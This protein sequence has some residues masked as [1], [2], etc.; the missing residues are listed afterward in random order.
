MLYTCTY[1]Y[2]YIYI[3]TYIHTYQGQKQLVAW[4]SISTSPP[5]RA[6]LQG[7]ASLRRHGPAPQRRPQARLEAVEEPLLA[8]SRHVRLG[9][10]AARCAARAS[11]SQNGCGR[12]RTA[13]AS[14]HAVWQRTASRHPDATQMPPMCHRATS[15][16]RASHRV[17]S[18]PRAAPIP[19][20]LR[21]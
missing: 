1:I 15:R 3:Y 2:I 17:P 21:A 18:S 9:P 13:I 14:R 20:R 19:S 6:D 10:R 7:L 5:E 8:E 4:R 11:A 12:T 16:R